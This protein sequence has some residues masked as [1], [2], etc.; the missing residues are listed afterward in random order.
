MVCRETSD[1]KPDVTVNVIFYKSSLNMRINFGA[2]V[3]EGLSE[4]ASRVP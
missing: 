2:T 4:T 3:N 1:R